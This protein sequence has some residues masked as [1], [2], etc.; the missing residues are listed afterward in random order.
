LE[1]TLRQ[2]KSLTRNVISSMRQFSLMS[3]F[4]SADKQLSVPVTPANEVRV[5]Q[6]VKE[7]DKQ[8]GFSQPHTHTH[9]HTHTR[10]S[11]QRPT[12]P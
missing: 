6:D 2:K 8:V 1:Q 3:L 11:S 12:H 5:S 10:F 4:S 7:T 9:T